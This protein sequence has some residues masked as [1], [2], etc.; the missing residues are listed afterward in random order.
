MRARLFILS[1]ALAASLTTPA[2]TLGSADVN[3]IL[4]LWAEGA[5]VFGDDCPQSQ[6]AVDTRCTGYTV[7]Y[8]PEDLPQGGLN[9]DPGIPGGRARAPW[10]AFVSVDDVVVHPDFTAEVVASRSGVAFEPAGTYDK[11]HLSEASVVAAVRMN[12]GSTISID[13][14]WTATEAGE[15][16]GNDGPLSDGNGFP[17]RHFNDRCVTINIDDHQKLARAEIDGTV[18]GV[19]I[20]GLSF[21]EG[22]IFD[23][24]FRWTIVTHGSCL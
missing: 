23:N 15:K 11:T 12:D 2:T 22:F 3:R 10:V 7:F 16:F 24:W 1:A 13:L 20:S 5:N 21:K 17:F 8:A 6:P 4:R 14:R 18:A 9:P 19:N